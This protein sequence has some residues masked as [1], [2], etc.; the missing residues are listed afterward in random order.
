MIEL[1]N[2]DYNYNSTVTIFPVSRTLS[3]NEIIDLNVNSV[4]QSSVSPVSDLDKIWRCPVINMQLFISVTIA[5]T[6]L[7]VI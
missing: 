4:L 1:C 5:T 7:L 3:N 2:G 6:D